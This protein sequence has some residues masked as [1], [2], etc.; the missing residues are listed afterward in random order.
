MSNALGY[1][2]R[3]ELLASG[4]ERTFLPRRPA[5]LSAILPSRASAKHSS[6]ARKDS[7]SVRV[8]LADEPPVERWVKRHLK[9]MLSAQAEGPA[10]AGRILDHPDQ[11][12]AMAAA[13]QK[14]GATLLLWLR[15]LGWQVTTDRDGDFT[16]GVASHVQA[17]GSTL[18]VGG[19]ART[20]G[21]LALQL[22]ESAVRALDSNRHTRQQQLA[23]A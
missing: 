6:S 12:A 13:A 9:A 23:A 10:A 16:V 11:G 15:L 7:P 3:E 1:R 17:D 8:K 19:C 5:W 14:E 18:R 22:F 2:P 21:E 20:D 4:V